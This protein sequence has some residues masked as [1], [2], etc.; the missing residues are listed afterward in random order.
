MTRISDDEIKFVI[1]CMEK[2]ME[3]PAEFK[4]AYIKKYTVTVPVGKIVNR[5]YNLW[6]KRGTF[7]KEYTIRQ[8]HEMEASRT[9]M[10]PVVINH[11][12]DMIPPRPSVGIPAKQYLLSSLPDSGELLVKIHNQNAETN[13]LL[14]EMISLQK[15]QIEIFKMLA[16][17]K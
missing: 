3:A 10:A 16:N 6:Y 17:K 8:A 5:A 11:K 4:Q 2:G 14:K 15:N 1:E 7:V 9:V 12:N 13:V